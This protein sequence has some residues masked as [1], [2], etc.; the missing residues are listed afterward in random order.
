[1]H[2]PSPAS[3]TVHVPPHLASSFAGLARVREE[4]ALHLTTELRYHLAEDVHVFV[5]A[6]LGEIATPASVFAGR[7]EGNGFH[8]RITRDLDRARNYLIDRYANDPDA[9]F[10]I[11]ASSRDSDLARFGVR[12]DYQSTKQVSPGP[13]FA[14]GDDD[15]RGRSCRA[16]RTCVTEFG[17]QGLELDATLLAWGTDLIRERGAWT[18]RMAKRYAKPG[19]VRDALQLRRNAY[20]VLLTRARDATVAFVPPIPVLDE[21]YTF[22]LDAGFRELAADQPNGRTASHVGSDS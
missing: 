11:V 2:A 8:S 1:M 18:N 13:W 5:E 20:R 15:P 7:L 19:S 22:L 3:W 9:R 21:T 16:L 12:N 14:E 4:S 6:L 17:C 10:G